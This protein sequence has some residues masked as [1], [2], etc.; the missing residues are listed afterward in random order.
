MTRKIALVTVLACAVSASAAVTGFDLQAIGPVNGLGQL[1]VAPGSTTVIDLYAVGTGLDSGGFNGYYST[2]FQFQNLA[3]SDIGGLY[4]AGV[5]NDDPA[6]ENY[7]TM[8]TTTVLGRGSLNVPDGALL[9]RIWLDAP[10]T[11]NTVGSVSTFIVGIAETTLG[12]TSVSPGTF[13]QDTLTLVTTPEPVSALLL[14]AG[15]PLIRRRR[16]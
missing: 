14:L 1:E 8:G 4:I 11:E 13:V 15:L 6:V 2:T 10:A 5:N 3:A 16:A 7:G 12:D 9:A